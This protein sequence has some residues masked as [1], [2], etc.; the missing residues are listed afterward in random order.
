MGMLKKA[1][2]YLL[3]DDGTE[4]KKTFNTDGK[5]SYVNVTKD[6][7][8]PK[9]VEEF[10]KGL[11]SESQ[12]NPVLWMQ[13]PDKDQNEGILKTIPM[14]I[15]RE[16]M[17]EWVEEVP[18]LFGKE[19]DLSQHA[20]KVCKDT[21]DYY[22]EKRKGVNSEVKVLA[23]DIEAIKKSLPENYNADEWRNVSLQEKYKVIS[24]ANI[25]NA[26]RKDKE[27]VVNTIN[28][29]IEGYREKCKAEIA[30]IKRLSAEGKQ[31]ISDKITDLKKSDH[32]T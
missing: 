19:I 29:T 25:S 7:M 27:T 31:I 11:I 26:V 9:K 2:T 4:C 13:L 14:T 30:E 28:Q 23:A 6:G 5:P 16:Q 1:E 15:T 3:L 8:T 17:I 12:I 21:E 20:L 18:S 22:F 10:L 32:F 24:D